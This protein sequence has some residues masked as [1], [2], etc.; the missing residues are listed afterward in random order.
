MYIIEA[1]NGKR[2]PVTIEP[3]EDGDFEQLDE[4]RYFFDWKIEQNQEV[5]KLQI[6]GASEILGLVSLQRIPSEWRIHIRML[7]VSSENK[8][9]NKKYDKIAGN[10]I[11]HAAK[12]AVGEYAEMACV[13]LRPKSEIAQHY[14]DKY[15]MRT[16]GL[17]LSTEVPEI[18]DLIKEYDHG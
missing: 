18:L 15:K 17:T 16:T 7:T 4:D 14:K 10:L 11:V 2:H 1:S 12:L 3:L 9:R 6:E 5:Y 13:S 8:G